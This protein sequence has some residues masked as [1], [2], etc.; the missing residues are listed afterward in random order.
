MPE[1]TPPAGDLERLRH[2]VRGT[3]GLLLVVTGAGVSHASGIATFRGSDPGAVWH[4]DVMEKATFAFFA[5]DPVE[6]WRWYL[7]RF[8]EL[9]SAA[10]NPAHHA[11]AAIERAQLARGGGFL[12]VTQNIDTLHERA[13]TQNLIKVHGSCDTARCPRA[14]C[15]FGAPRGLL[16]RDQVSLSAFVAQPALAN[17]PRCPACA[18][19]LRPHV[20]WFDE[21]YTEH[22]GYQWQRTSAAAALAETVLFVGTSFSV[23]VTDKVMTEAAARGARILS[24]DPGAEPPPHQGI[25]L[26][27][28]RAEAVLPLLAGEPARPNEHWP[29]EH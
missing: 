21:L 16:T 28:Q 7:R 5:R 6:S 27:R 18:A 22:D 10:P 25:V 15:R 4:H 23:G 9:D 11:L 24:I 2:A 14:G 8:A 12:L 1:A 3:R 13:G 19:V 26:I 20:L 29:N 17:L